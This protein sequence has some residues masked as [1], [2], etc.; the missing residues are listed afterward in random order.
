MKDK[1]TMPLTWHNCQS[2][3]PTEPYN[4]RLLATNGNFVFPVEYDVMDGWYDKDRGCYLPFEMLWEYYWAD[5]EQTVRECTE[6]KGE[7]L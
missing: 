5:L 4:S 6:F 7:L 3:P 2:Y 1:F